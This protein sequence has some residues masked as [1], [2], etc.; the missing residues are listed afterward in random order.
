MRA[1]NNVKKH[2]MLQMRAC[3]S[4][5]LQPAFHD[6]RRNE[7][8]LRVD[9]TLYKLKAYIAKLKGHDKPEHRDQKF[10]SNPTAEAIQ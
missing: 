3:L 6:K 4:I 10:K 9:L 5:K 2:K 8:L 7:E 1:F